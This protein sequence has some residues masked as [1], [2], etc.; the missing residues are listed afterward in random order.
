MCFWSKW[1]S[2]CGLDDGIS[3]V[4]IP[5]PYKHQVKLSKVQREISH[6]FIYW[7]SPRLMSLPSVRQAA[8]S[9]SRQSVITHMYP[10]Q[11]GTRNTVS[12]HSTTI[13]FRGSPKNSPK[14]RWNTVHMP[15]T[16]G[17]H[18]RVDFTGA[19][20]LVVVTLSEGLSEFIVC[21]GG[22]EATTHAKGQ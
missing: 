5:N 20:L 11:L 14:S 7:N 18:Y 21:D 15:S 9:S 12:N 6:L 13:E 10:V 3:A 22:L 19:E 8:Q 17:T 16:P 4:L 2:R 1:M